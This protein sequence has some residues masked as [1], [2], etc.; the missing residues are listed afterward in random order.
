MK[1]ILI[2]DDEPDIVELVKNRLE[3]N[4]Y[5]VICAPDGKE[6]IKKAQ[7]QRPDLILMDILMPHMSGGD[8]VRLLRADAATKHIPIMFLTAI[9][10]LS[11]QGGED[12]GVKV[13]EQFYPS[14]SKPFKPEKLLFEIKRLIGDK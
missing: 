6:G 11:P 9:T 1:R 8:A 14:I 10:A 12:K 7:Q 13:G 4:N 2:V 5:D 3:E